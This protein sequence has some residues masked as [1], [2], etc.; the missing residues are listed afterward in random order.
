M[1]DENMIREIEDAW[2][3][4]GAPVPLPSFNAPKTRTLRCGCRQQRVYIGIT[5]RTDWRT[6]DR[7]FRHDLLDDGGYLWRWA[8]R[9]EWLKLADC[10]IASAAIT[11]LVFGGS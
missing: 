10:G 7:C 11:Y 8:R 4:A 1:H 6:Y 3:K 9:N 2:R 5:G